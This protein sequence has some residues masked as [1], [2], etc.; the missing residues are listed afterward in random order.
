MVGGLT[1]GFVGLVVL[2]GPDAL[3]ELG[4]QAS[5]LPRQAAILSAALCYATGTILARRLASLDALV[6]AATVMWTT[7]AIMIPF[8]LWVDRPWAQE[9]SVEAVT[10]VVWLG[11]AATALATI[12]YFRVI[13]S[14]GPTFLSLMNYMIPVVTLG[15]GAIVLDEEIGGTI[16]IGLILI[17]IGLAI[18]Q[19]AGPAGRSR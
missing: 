14:A 7:C 6:S 12:I 19:L 10:T 18:S 5:D 2:L 8:A 16:L 4:G 3:L 15:A 13:Q 11:V 1:V 17:L 9:W